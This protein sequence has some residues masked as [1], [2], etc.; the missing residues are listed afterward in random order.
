MQDQSVVYLPSVTLTLCLALFPYFILFVLSHPGSTFCIFLGK[1]L[2]PAAA[3]NEAD[4]GKLQQA[5]AAEPV[6]P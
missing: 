6:L 4:K 1:N 3:A 2:R 5:A